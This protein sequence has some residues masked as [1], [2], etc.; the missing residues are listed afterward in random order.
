MSVATELPLLDL[1]AILISAIAFIVTGVG[2][3]ASLKFYRDGVELQTTAQNIL[4]RIDERVD[5][6]RTQVGGVFEKTLDAAIGRTDQRQVAAEQKRLLQEARDEREGDARVEEEHEE[7][8]ATAGEADEREN[9]AGEV[10]DYFAFK[11]L[12]Y[13]DVSSEDAR[14]VFN[15]GAQH[16]FNLFDGLPGI[17]F[18]GYFHRYEPREIVARCR[19]LLNNIALAYKRLD[20]SLVTPQQLVAARKLLDQISITVLVP[21]DADTGEMEERIAEYQPDV[22]EVE[23]TLIRPG[24]LQEA[25][26]QEYAAMGF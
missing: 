20:S 1:L 8:A 26:D 6:L 14:A 24:D 19:F 9:L 10:L 2:F 22:R 12:R 4:S 18:F 13:T 21:E 3:F 16:G 15:L 17:V 7:L 11:G 5:A 23:V 25:I